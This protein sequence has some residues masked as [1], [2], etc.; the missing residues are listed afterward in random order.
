MGGKY[1]DGKYV[2]NY[3]VLFLDLLKTNGR[4]AWGRLKNL[5]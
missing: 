1:C 3:N 4:R 2:G 5:G